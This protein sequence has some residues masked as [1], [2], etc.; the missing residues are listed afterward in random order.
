MLFSYI[1]VSGRPFAPPSFSGRTP[2]PEFDRSPKFL[3]EARVEES[4]QILRSPEYKLWLVY[5]L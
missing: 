1:V 5:F 4:S 3:Q 2:G